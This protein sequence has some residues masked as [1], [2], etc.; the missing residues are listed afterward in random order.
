MLQRKK[1][2]TEAQRHGVARRALCVAPCLCASVVK[3]PRPDRSNPTDPN[4]SLTNDHTIWVKQS[5]YFFK[6]FII[7]N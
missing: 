4:T 7:F 6:K 3:Q 1:I 2:T 5:F